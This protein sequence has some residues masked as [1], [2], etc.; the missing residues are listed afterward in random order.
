MPEANEK[1]S[2]R[3]RVRLTRIIDHSSRD[4]CESGHDAFFRQNKC[5]R[6]HR[7]ARVERMTA[8]VPKRRAVTD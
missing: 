6:R 7:P 1:R 4:G 5:P 3:N 2:R 8:R